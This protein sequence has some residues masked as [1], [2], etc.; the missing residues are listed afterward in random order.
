MGKVQ[1]KQTIELIAPKSTILNIIIY[2]H[3]EVS[4]FWNNPVYK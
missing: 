2:K 4:S 3:V 1:N